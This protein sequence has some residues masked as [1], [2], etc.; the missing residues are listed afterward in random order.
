MGASIDA[1]TSHDAPPA[2]I[3]G[4]GAHSVAEACMMF[5]KVYAALL[6]LGVIYLL[7]K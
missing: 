7:M 1:P 6:L 2:G 5:W 3:A 4:T